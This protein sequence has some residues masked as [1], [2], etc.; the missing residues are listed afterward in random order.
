LTNKTTNNDQRRRRWRVGASSLLLVATLPATALAGG[1]HTDTYA[2]ITVTCTSTNANSLPGE[3]ITRYGLSK[4]DSYGVL[5]CVAQQLNEDGLPENLSTST[6]ATY[7]TIGKARRDI[8][9][10]QV[11]EDDSITRVGSYRVMDRVPIEFEVS[12]ELPD[13]GTVNFTFVDE[14]PKY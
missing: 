8:P 4:D 6:T 14:Y 11:L 1:Q 10:K 2:D 9:L 5:S 12:M 13:V 7:R 3:V